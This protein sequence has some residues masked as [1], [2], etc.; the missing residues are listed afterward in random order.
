MES[1]P[2]PPRRSREDNQSQGANQA[3][4]NGHKWYIPASEYRT[5]TLIQP[6][7]M[8][9]I[10]RAERASASGQERRAT[11]KPRQTN[12]INSKAQRY[13]DSNKWIIEATRSRSPIER[14]GYSRCHVR[15]GR[16]GP[17]YT[18][19]TSD[20]CFPFNEARGRQRVGQ[21]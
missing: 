14:Q 17:K 10:V 18:R 19:P 4:H 21:T 9:S 8:A 13:F 5:S 16:W 6:A 12:Q 11:C 20:P 7:A 1:G 2:T 3:G 15:Q